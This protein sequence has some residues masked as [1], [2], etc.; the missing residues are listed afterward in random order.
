VADKEFCF[1]FP[2][3]GAY[4]PCSL[5]L[6]EVD[7][8]NVE[9]YVLERDLKSFVEKLASDNPALLARKLR[10]FIND[11]PVEIVKLLEE[12]IKN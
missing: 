10:A 12:Y 11:A 3:D 7:M 9:Y 6:L 5:T 4:Y 1:F 8:S 2:R